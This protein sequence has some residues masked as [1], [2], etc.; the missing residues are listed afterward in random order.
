MPVRR[1]AA[2][3]VALLAIAALAG[4]AG[5]RGG[6][7]GPAP[8]QRAWFGVSL[9]PGGDAELDLH[10]AGRLRSDADVRALA[11]R[12]A[13][14]LFPGARGVRVRTEQGHGI[15]FARAAIDR[16]YRTGR[17]PALRIDTAGTLRLL[18]ERGFRDTSMRL[19]LPPS[20]PATVRTDGEPSDRT[21]RLR[22]DTRTPVVDVE[23]RPSPA[24]WLAALALPVLGAV[25][26]ALAFF[27]RRRA[28]ALPAAGIAVAAAIVA[29]AAPAGRQGD[30][31]GVAGLLGGTALEVA[32]VAPLAAVPIG[33]PAAM[34]LT[35]VVVR[36]LLRPDDFLDHE[37]K[38]RDTGVFW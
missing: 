31:L 7:G 11:R 35:V 15:P 17:N 24:G 34:L 29:V 37:T 30:N 16:A 4:C 20:V 6:G 13:A 19:R 9:L 21:W 8:P 32:T 12:I 1:L 27:V 18:L 22:P 25:G 2:L 36:Y 38:P 33:L 3:G 23:L 5:G 14:D 10:A 28:F 26:V